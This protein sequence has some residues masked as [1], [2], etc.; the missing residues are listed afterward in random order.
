MILLAGQIESIS[1]RRDK[2]IKLI[3][4]SQ[5]LNPNDLTDIFKLNQ[6]LCYIAVKPEPFIK[7]EVALLDNLKTDYD[8]SK[9]PSQRLRGILYKNYE[10]NS[11]GYKDFNN[12]YVA[13]MELIC[14]HYKSKLD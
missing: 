9:T 10:Q 13:K 7:D 4:G 5:E 1:T 2:T 11:E 12:Y 3:I 8:N 14:N 6:Q